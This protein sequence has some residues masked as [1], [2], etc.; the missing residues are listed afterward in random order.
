MA[1]D[2]RPLT[3]GDRQ[4]PTREAFVADPMIQRAASL[5]PALLTTDDPEAE[6]RRFF[7]DDWP[8]MHDAIL[9]FADGMKTA[10]GRWTDSVLPVLRACSDQLRALGFTQAPVLSDRHYR[11]MMAHRAAH[12]RPRKACRR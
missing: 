7:Q 3:L 12:P 4:Y 2:W 6:M 11:R 9:A 8:H 5:W 10:M 1:T